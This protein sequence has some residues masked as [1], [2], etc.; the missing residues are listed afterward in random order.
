MAKKNKRRKK[1]RA[2]LVFLEVFVLVLAIGLGG[3]YYLVQKQNKEEE[4]APAGEIIVTKEEPAYEEE[5]E[6]VSEEEED[7]PELI[8]DTSKYGKLLSDADRCREEHIYS[9]EALSP[10]Q[11]TLLFAGDVGLAEGYANLGQLLQ[12]GGDISEGFDENTL[13]TMRNADVFM[14]NNEFTYTNR[15]TPTPEKE[16]TFRCDPKHVHYLFDMGVDVVSLANNHTYDFGEVSILDTLDTLEGAGMP[17]VGAGYNINEAV[18]PTYFIINDVRIAIVSATQIERVSYPDTKGA[19]EDKPGTFRCWYNDRVVEVVEEAKACS[20]FV[21]AYIHWGTE[22][23]EA[24]DWAQLELAPKLA[25]AGA[26]L[27]VGDHPHVL[28]RL[29]YIGD[30]PLIYS[31]GNYWFNSKTLDSGLLEVVLDNNGSMESL[32]FIP[33]IQSGC[34]T[35]IVTG[36]EGAR[37]LNYMQS[38]SSKVIIDEDGYITKK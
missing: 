15:G 1:H 37:I 3:I 26:D 21:I 31:M 4:S 14:V 27:I 7:E 28:Q 33:A 5:I 20:D 36:G 23:E 32:R 38:I 18:K 17:Y 29:D 30:T 8:Q 25:N 13:L 35:K 24:P 16:Y 12:R 19:T 10:S 9:K 22:L 11:I 2:L 6:E 34:R